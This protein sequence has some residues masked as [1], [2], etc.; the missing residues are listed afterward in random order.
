MNVEELHK[1][2][3]GY[4]PEL[5]LLIDLSAFG[6][7]SR[8]TARGPDELQIIDRE[9]FASLI[10]SHKLASLVFPQLSE[11][12]EYMPEKIYQKIKNTNLR[13]TRRS[14][15]QIEQTIHLQ[16]L[17]DQEKIPAIFFKGIVLSQRLYGNPASKNS[18][19]I[20]LLMPLEH[21]ARAT[22][23]L[24]DKGYRMTYP[25]ITMT[26]R[27]TRMN[28]RIS[29]H[30]GFHHPQKG[31][32]LELH[33]N[34]TNPRSLLPLYFKELHERSE[35]IDLNGHPARTLSDEDYLIYLAV[36]GAK[37]QWYRLNWLL[38]FS[39][40]LSQTGN[41]T[42]EKARQQL[43]KLKLEKCWQQ[44]CLMS[45]L[46]YGMPENSEQLKT[47][48]LSESMVQK[49]LDALGALKSTEAIDKLKN[50]PYQLSLR[51]ALAYKFNLLFRLR[52]HH[53][54]WAQMPL[55]DSLF[56]LYYPL[57]PI[58]WLKDVLS[59]KR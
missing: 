1:K 33:W 50:M 36:H 3:Q 6:S 29:H 55:P 59:G 31:V 47:D 40:M 51:T 28:Y 35:T 15:V 25:A 11:L 49:P 27:Q 12:K 26:P 2:L 41:N 24:Q 30:Y 7:K 21:V 56:F 54:N 32:H 46:I 20:D 57:R 52:T 16:Q 5:R 9:H 18:I 14:L 58:L 43:K 10:T 17:L 23:L 44:A 45:H 39:T 13:H 38:D 48:K 53:T 37:H 4:S 42:Q 34:L 22:R 8:E 19:D